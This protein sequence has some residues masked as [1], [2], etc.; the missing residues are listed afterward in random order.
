MVK[1]VAIARACT[2]TLDQDGK[3]A[4]RLLGHLLRCSAVDFERY[5]ARSRRPNPKVHAAARLDLGTDRQ[6][7]D[8]RRASGAGL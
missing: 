1:P 5:F 4:L 8:R 6:P 7:P 3:I 2:D